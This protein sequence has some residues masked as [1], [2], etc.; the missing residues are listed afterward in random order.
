MIKSDRRDAH[1]GQKSTFNSSHDFWD[2]L[3]SIEGLPIIHAVSRSGH[4]ILGCKFKI[5]TDHCALCVLTKRT[6]QSR[7]LSR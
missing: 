4:Y 7:R 6:P 2:A 1:V 5:H 3:Y